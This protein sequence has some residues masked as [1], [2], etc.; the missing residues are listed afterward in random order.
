MAYIGR[1]DKDKNVDLA[2]R[3]FEEVAGH[4][5]A[6]ELHIAGT[7]GIESQLRQ[8]AAKS[9]YANRIKFHGWIKDI[10]AFY[11]SVDLFVFLSAHESFGNVIAEALLTGLPV[12]TSNVPVFREIY[13]EGQNFIL[14]DPTDY[15]TIRQN[16]LKSIADYPSL[17][18][19]AYQKAG[20]I[21]KLFDL[22]NHLLQVER[23]YHEG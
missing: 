3:L 12:L 8:Q 6:L 4:D 20:R 1:L 9:P 7:S 13:G 14:G 2:I 11:A 19:N 17:A 18:Q 16:F 23:V 22:E 10:S 15:E 5:H 21:I